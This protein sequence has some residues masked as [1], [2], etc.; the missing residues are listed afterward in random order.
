MNKIHIRS[1]KPDDLK[2]FTSMFST[3]FRDD[4]KFDISDAK[5]NTL[6]GDITRDVQSGIL[7]L[8]LLIVDGESAG[9]ANYQID[10]SKSDWCEKEGWGFIREVYIH[11]KYRGRKFGNELVNY[12]EERLHEKGVDKIYLT[13]DETG[14][15]WS[16]C[17]Y[18]ETGETSRI[19]KDPIFEKRING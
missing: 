5:V 4:F 16:D 9:F 1:Y 17:G 3:Y 6:C 19:N 2:D 7:Y 12:I 18:K 8:D 14:K 13:S 15:F 11:K 10:S